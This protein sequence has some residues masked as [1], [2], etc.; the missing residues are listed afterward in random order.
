MVKYRNPKILVA[1]LRGVGYG[2]Y[3][4]SPTKIFYVKN[5]RGHIFVFLFDQYLYQF[6]DNHV[7]LIHPRSLFAN[8]VSDSEHY[9][10]L[11]WIP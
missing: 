11:E 6:Y 10:I 1:F 5:L 9:N 8:A 7:K 4:D 3:M 2:F